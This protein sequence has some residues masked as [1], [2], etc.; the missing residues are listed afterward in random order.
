[1]TELEAASRIIGTFLEELS[2]RGA[3]SVVVTHMADEIG[4]YTGCR[5]D[6]IEARGLEEKHNLIVDRTPVIGF[7]ARSTPELILKRLYA[8]ARG[9]DGEIY[10]K[11][12]DSFGNGV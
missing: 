12:L 6:G 3:Y 2:T 4:K 7:H 8:K 11:V 10:R 5:V 9:D 1:M